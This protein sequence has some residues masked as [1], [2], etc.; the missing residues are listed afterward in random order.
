MINKLMIDYLLI[1]RVSLFNEVM[2]GQK[3]DETES[4]G[5][6]LVLEDK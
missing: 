5:K 6:C 3:T 4:D 1:I 2:M